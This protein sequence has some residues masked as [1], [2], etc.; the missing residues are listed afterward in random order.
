MSLRCF[1]LKLEHDNVTDATRYLANELFGEEGLVIIDGNEKE[2]KKHFV[3]FMEREFLEQLSH[4]TTL[5][6]AE[7]LQELGHNIQVNPR[8]INLFYLA[9]GLRGRIIEQ[10][11][12]YA[13]VDSSIS[14]NR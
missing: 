4:K 14:W 2:L 10:N 7:A 11:D 1:L 9:E 3:P 5:P 6:K 13:V 12:Q 8:E